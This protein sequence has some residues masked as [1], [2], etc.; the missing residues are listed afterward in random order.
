MYGDE[1]FFG[2]PLDPR[3][4]QN[5]QLPRHA[6]DR[7]EEAEDHPGA[8]ALYSDTNTVTLLFGT[9]NPGKGLKVTVWVSWAPRGRR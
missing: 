5:E 9:K 8:L 7:Q 3:S 6:G 2:A 4:A 1:L